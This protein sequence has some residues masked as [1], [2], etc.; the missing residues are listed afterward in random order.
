MHTLLYLLKDDIIS[1][2]QFHRQVSSLSKLTLYT[3]TFGRLDDKQ[4]HCR[5][6]EECECEKLRLLVICRCTQAGVKFGI[7]FMSCSE[8]GNEVARGAAKCIA[9]LTTMTG[10]YPK[11]SLLPVLSITS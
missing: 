8:N 2:A 9:S 3:V 10:I 5:T 6:G 1:V 4:N 7:H 11:I